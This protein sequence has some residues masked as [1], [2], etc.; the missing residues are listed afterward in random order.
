MPL[1]ACR[2]ISLC[3]CTRA[4]SA[5]ERG[6]AKSRYREARQRTADQRCCQTV[7][8]GGTSMLRLCFLIFMYI[9]LHVFIYWHL[10]FKAGV[11]FSA[12]TLLVG[13]QEGN[14]ACK[15]LIGDVLAWLSVRSEVQMMCIWSSWCHCHAI[16]SCSS[17]IQ[18]GLPFWCQLTQVVLEKS[19]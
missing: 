10:W 6:R 1:P 4:W 17:K 8:A 5:R 12:L 9:Y 13:L 3:T 19:W 18:N 2:H 16:I 15:I 14:P 11:S 7:G